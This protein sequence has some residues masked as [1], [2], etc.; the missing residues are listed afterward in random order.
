MFAFG[1]QFYKNMVFDNPAW[2][3]HT[4]DPD[5]DTQT[6]DEKSAP[7]LN[8]TDADLTRFRARGGKLI[9]YHGWSDAAIAP[10]NA[11][12]YYDSVLAKMGAKE[13]GTF[14]RL[15]MVPGMQHCGGGAGPNDFGQL[16]V[17]RDPEHSV[18]AAVER[19]VEQGIA[20]EQVI[21]TKHASDS[22]Q[23]SAIVRTRPLCAYPLVARY[24]GSGSTD[25][26][27]NFTCGKPEAK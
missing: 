17:G 8:A 11:I 4:F 3:Y 10:R 18:N 12:N 14:V 26:A 1:T 16:S 2:D 25:D 7:V 22:D 13:A 27:G 5:R 15:F 24:K 9:L 6:A 19:W 21:A 23:K 20:P